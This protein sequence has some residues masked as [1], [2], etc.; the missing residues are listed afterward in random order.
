MPKTRGKHNLGQADEELVGAAGD[1]AEIFAEAEGGDA[2]LERSA[3]AME[4][5]LE[6]GFQA[7]GASDAVF[8]V[9]EL[10]GGEFLPAR[11]Y[12]SLI[13]QAA[14]EKLD[15]GERETHLASEANEEN[16]VEGVRGIAALAAGAMRRGEE[17]EPF[18]V[19][20]GGGVEASTAREFPNFHV[21]TCGEKSLT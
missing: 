3:V 19:A 15:F 11:S 20:D 16:A 12:G 6:K 1:G 8:D 2:L 7:K 14:K 9:H 4:K 10:S 17:A 13:V 18:V 5:T 21:L